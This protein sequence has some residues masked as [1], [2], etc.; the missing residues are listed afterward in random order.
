[1]EK[2]IYKVVC[3][4]NGPSL[5]SNRIQNLTIGKV[6]ETT[7]NLIYDI[8]VV[9]DLGN[10]VNYSSKR[11]VDLEIWREMRINKILNG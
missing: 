4:D 2:K 5:I 10:Y 6:Y 3:V 9:N 1:M 11:F 8:E 7:D